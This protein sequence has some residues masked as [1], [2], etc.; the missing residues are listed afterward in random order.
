MW[1]YIET[2][3]LWFMYDSIMRKTKLGQIPRA[4]GDARHLVCHL[5]SR[6]N[7]L[8]NAFRPAQWNT[9]PVPFNLY[10]KE[11]TAQPFH[12][13]THSFKL[14]A[15]IFHWYYPSPPQHT[16]SPLH[17]PLVPG[18]YLGYRSFFKASEEILRPQLE[19]SLKRSL[20]QRSEDG[21]DKP[22]SHTLWDFWSQEQPQGLPFSLSACGKDSI[23]YS[24]PTSLNFTSRI[25]IYTT[26]GNS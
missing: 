18:I 26:V 12:S 14:M 3:V 4:V 16:Y 5:T 11:T 21:P 6:Q 25:G 15:H 17:L 8:Q 20:K 10:G 2:H 7:W 24:L 9:T 1:V 23:P 19:S 22:T 13:F